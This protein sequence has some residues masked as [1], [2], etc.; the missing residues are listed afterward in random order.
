MYIACLVPFKPLVSSSLF[1][2]TTHPK[3]SVYTV[4]VVVL[5]GSVL[6]RKVTERRLELNL[7][8][9]SLIDLLLGLVLGDAVLL[10]DL[11]DETFSVA[12]D[13][14]EVLRGEFVKGGTELG[15]GCVV[16]HFCL[17]VAA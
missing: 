13:G 7:F 3:Y 8:G 16:G 10:G 6:V 17:V 14:G 11:V 4:Y 1:C 15:L 9:K 5:A 2:A 12:G